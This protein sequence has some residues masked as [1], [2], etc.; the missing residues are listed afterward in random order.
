[1][2]KHRPQVVGINERFRQLAVESLS[3]ALTK[4]E[5]Q[6]VDEPLVLVKR[7]HR[8]AQRS[9]SSRS[10][11]GRLEQVFAVLRSVALVGCGNELS[12]RLGALRNAG[13]DAA[14]PGVT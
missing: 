12:N 1:M 8:S 7:G 14:P 3:R 9:K 4:H 10:P 6:V 5:V 11:V 13:V 2:L